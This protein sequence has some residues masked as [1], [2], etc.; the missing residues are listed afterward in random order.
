M[1]VVSFIPSVLLI[2]IASGMSVVEFMQN[3]GSAER[4]EAN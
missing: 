2:T 4:E 1:A 3:C